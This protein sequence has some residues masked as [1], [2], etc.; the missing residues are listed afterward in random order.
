MVKATI[1]EAEFVLINIY[2]PT[3]GKE[4][5]AFWNH[6]QKEVELPPCPVIIGGDFNCD[7]DNSFDRVGPNTESDDGAAQLEL[8]VQKW[9]LTDCNFSQQPQMLDSK[10]VRE[11]AA[12]QHT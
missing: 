10:S 6:I 7:I 2:T 3:D 1:A 9:G 8:L 11:Y 5:R 12:T 4:R